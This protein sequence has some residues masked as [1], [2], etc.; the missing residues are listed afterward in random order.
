MIMETNK[1][2]LQTK[3]KSVGTAYLMWFFIGM[4][5][6]YLGN[7]GRQ[8]L[9]WFMAITWIIAPFIASFSH[10]EGLVI[11]LGFGFSIV[12]GIWYLL[13]VF[14]ISSY[15]NSYNKRITD[16]IQNLEL[17]EQARLRDE[18]RLSGQN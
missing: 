7:W 4:H 11:G 5:H 10:Y 15:V 9:L 17:M 3:I 18:Q 6:A 2:Y 13:D 14:F 8:L 1:H 12:A 16:E